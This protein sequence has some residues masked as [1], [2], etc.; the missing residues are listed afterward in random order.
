MQLVLR[1]LFFLS[2]VI[3]PITLVPEQVGPL[4][5]RLL[6]ELN[7]AA[8]FISVGRDLM[9]GLVLPSG[10]SVAYLVAWT[11]ASA[12]RRPLGLPPLGPGHRRGGMS[13]DIAIRVRNLSKRFYL[14]PDRRGSLRSGRSA[15]SP[16]RPTTDSGP[17]GT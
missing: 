3:Y 4:P 1:L 15:A 6:I 10:W 2:A 7:P 14:A 16:G 17:C 9:Y 13:D 8:Q 12:S 11:A 5:A